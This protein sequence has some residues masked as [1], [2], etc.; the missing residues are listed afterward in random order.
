MYIV[1]YIL[2]LRNWLFKFK[3]FQ[4]I[5]Y[6]IKIFLKRAFHFHVLPSKFFKNLFKSIKK[7]FKGSSQKHQKTF[8]HSKLPGSQTW[9]VIIWTCFI[10]RHDMIYIYFGY[11]LEFYFQND[12]LKMLK[13]CYKNCCRNERMVSKCR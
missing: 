1:F 11:M 10:E 9:K 5:Q 4:S 3:S 12:K 8:Q 6:H 13:I 7:I 2:I